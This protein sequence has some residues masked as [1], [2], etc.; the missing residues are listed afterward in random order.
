V[1]KKNN[2]KNCWEHRKCGRELGG[3]KAFAMGACPVSTYTWF[4]GYHGGKNGGRTCWIIGGTMCGGEV[5]GSFEEKFKVCGKCSF[6]HAVK[7]EEGNE[8]IPSVH[9]LQKLEDH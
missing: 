6:Y 3:D 8:M 4:D 7:E 9:L 2:K 5:H 1:K